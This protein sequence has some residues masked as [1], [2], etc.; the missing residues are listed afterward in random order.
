M[1]KNILNISAVVIL[2]VFSLSVNAAPIFIEK[3]KKPQT[4]SRNPI[5]VTANQPTSSKISSIQ[6]DYYKNAPTYKKA[7]TSNPWQGTSFGRFT[8]EINIYDPKTKN[9]YNQY[10]YLALMK[11]RGNTAA[12]NKTAKQIQQ[13][14]VFNPQK[15]Q[16]V[17]ASAA[18]GNPIL[19]VG[20]KANE[21]V[22]R[23][24]V[25]NDTQQGRVQPQPIQRQYV[26][27]GQGDAIPSRVHGAYDEDMKDDPVA[28]P[29]PSNQPIFLR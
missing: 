12:Y 17:M 16:S 2:S 18:Q 4:T 24:T 26:T 11:Q 22:G 5:I 21:D 13:M 6:A 9:N 3:Y 29:R 15:F 8:E 10:D 28:K 23:Q 25:K 14:G 20:A 7:K 27:K 1:R 19:P